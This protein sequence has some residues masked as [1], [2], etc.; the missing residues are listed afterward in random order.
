[1]I[2][3]LF[4]I[5]LQNDLLTGFITGCI[6][7]LGIG[8]AIYGGHY[9]YSRYNSA[10]H[11]HRVEAEDKGLVDLNRA[12]SY[13]RLITRRVRFGQESGVQTDPIII[14]PAPQPLPVQLPTPSPSPEV[15]EKESQTDLSTLPY[16]SYF[17]H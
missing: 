17:L 7:T 8:L 16:V 6:G 12:P 9:L 2:N 13:A 3:N 15:V 1:M 14:G 4:D 5:G 10:S 11:I